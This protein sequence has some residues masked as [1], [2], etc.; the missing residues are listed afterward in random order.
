[1]KQK[2]VL[3]K[4]RV[5]FPVKRQG[6]GGDVGV[7]LG[8]LYLASYARQNT[9]ADIVIR[10]YRLDQAFG[11]VI[12][13]E[14][15][16]RDAT[17]IGTGACTVEFPDA[18]EIL[19]K[20]KEM[21]K[22]TV[23]GGIFPTSNVSSVL[24]NKSIDFIVRGEGERVF[25]NLIRALSGKGPIKDVPGI[26]YI[27]DGNVVSNPDETLIPNLSVMPRP[28]YDLVSMDDYIKFGSAPVYASRGCPMRCKFCTPNEFW[29]F[30][31]RRRSVDDIIGEIAQLKEFGF[32]KINFKDESIATDQRWA[33]E[34]F[35][36]LELAKFGL[37]YK[38]KLRADQVNDVL[39]KQMRHAGVDV[40]HTGIESLSQRTLDSMDKRI[41]AEKIES[42][43]ELILSNG[44][45][46]NPVYMLGWPGEYPE[47]L[48]KNSRFIERIGKRKGVLTYV[49]FI[50]PHPGSG[51]ENQD[52][53][54]VLS[55]DY[56]R[57]SHKQ[58]VAA[59]SSL[60]KDGVQLMVN[61]YDQIAESTNTR[62][63]NPAIP[64][65]YVW[66]ILKR[67]RTCFSG[68]SLE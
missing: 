58:P 50:T 57:Y 2:V 31:Y 17:I 25:T 54:F 45:I 59:P 5:K 49:S 1:M 38:V 66:E 13:M 23:M 7:P 11:N 24:R 36:E 55:R 37:S 6:N 35:K 47:D 33:L 48:E 53:L 8:L 4:P 10:D 40:I 30:T 27:R 65:N 39:L 9:D 44:I 56:S 62:S 60:G 16:F 41:T 14:R 61:A 32:D 34:L 12:D 3:V 21:G 46:I 51:I 29:R 63:V 52:G 15:D 42:L 43:V 19:K 68:V 28:S 18:L 20:A 64:D 26:S 22:T 67:N